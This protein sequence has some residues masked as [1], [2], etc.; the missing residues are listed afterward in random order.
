ME[1]KTNGTGPTF[2]SSSVLS[3]SHIQSEILSQSK[4]KEV[5]EKVENQ[6]LR[7]KKFNRKFCPHGLVTV[8]CPILA[9]KIKVNKQMTYCCYKY[10]VNN[11]DN[12]TYTNV[13]KS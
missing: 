8:V 9:F 6:L 1:F 7:N 10:P 2:V 13:M 5:I 4:E 12:S 3:K 11:P